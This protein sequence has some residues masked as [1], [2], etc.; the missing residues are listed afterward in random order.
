MV[1]AGD[2][3]PSADFEIINPELHMAT[4]NSPDARLIVEFN[5]E[6][7]KGYIPAD[8]SNGLP[9]GVIPVDAIFTPIR[10][11]NYSIEPT[12]IGQD[13]SY[14]RLILEVWT[15]G[16]TTPIKAVSESAEI[17]IGQL[18]LFQE[19]ALAPLGELG[20]KLPHLLI[21]AEQYN[22]PIE[23]LGLSVRTL[24]C[25]RRG[26][27]SKV[28]ELLER[29]EEELLEMRNFGRRSLQEMQENLKALG[30]S[31]PLEAPQ[32]EGEE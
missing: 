12:R 26:N 9:I 21:P 10:R 3:S 32:E 29:S 14:E 16:T 11:V 17:L 25:L 18:T 28:G 1:S 13:A 31:Y 22:M 5:V 2:I 23:Q 27:I 4:L 30:I 8:K 20:K 24:N 7:G 19:L 6:L 15:D